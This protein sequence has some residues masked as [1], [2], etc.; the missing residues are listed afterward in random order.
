MNRRQS[1][2]L[3]AML[4]L[5]VLLAIGGL[6][7]LMHRGAPLS[8]I[9]PQVIS[10]PTGAP[11]DGWDHGAGQDCAACHDTRQQSVPEP[12]LRAIPEAA[13]KALPQEGEGEEGEGP[14]QRLSFFVEQRAYPGKSLPSGARLMAFQQTQAMAD[15][16]ARSQEFA[17]PAQR[18][19][20]IGPAPMKNSIMGQHTADVSGRV[21]AL[22]VDPRNSNVVYLGAAQGGVWKTTNGGDSWTPLT[23]DQP[24][25]AIGALALDPQHPDT[26]YAGT[27]EP[28][29]GLDN[30]YGAGILKSTN[31]GSSWQRLGASE[32][33]GLG[34]ASIVINPINSNVL[35]VASSSTGVAGP[36]QP[37]RGIFKSTNGGASWTALLTCADCYGAS[38]LVMDVRSPAKLYAAFWSAGIYK[39]TDGGATW[40]QLTGGLPP[41]NFGRIELAIGTSDPSVLYAGYHYTVQGQY[42]GAVLFKT[43]DG[44]A[45]WTWLQQTPNYCGGQCWY[46]NIIAVDPTSA[47]VVYLGGQ[48]RYEWQPVTRIKEVVIRSNDGGTTWQDMSPNDSAAHTLHPD[49]HAIAF[50]PQNHNTVWV[51]NDG[52]V[53]KSTDGGRTWINRNTNLATLQFTGIGLHPTNGN[54]VFGGMQDNNK[55]KTS[56][57][58]AWDALDAGDGGYAA[59]DPFDPRF[60]YGSRYSISFQRNDKSGSAPVADWPVKTEGISRQDRA[61][62]YAPFALDPSSQGVLYYG[63][64][65]LYRT[66]N[67]GENWMPISGD[68]TKGA[69]TNGRLSAIAVAPSAAGTI[70]VGT[71]D[72]NVQV[73]TNTGGSW[74]NATKAPLPNRW[75]SDIAVPHNDAKTAYVVYNG[76][77]SHTPQTPGHVFKTTDR[78]GSWRDISAN[79][80]DVPVLSIVLDRDGPGILYIGTDV[81]VFRSLDDGRRWQPFSDGLPNVAVVDLA[82]NPDSDVLVAATHGRSVYRL[83]IGTP[84]PTPTCTPGTPPPVTPA[85][86]LPLI[87]KR[88][89]PG[90][91]TS[92]PTHTPAGPTATPTGM[93]I[94]TPT[95]TPTVGGTVLPTRTPTATA[96]PTA[97]PTTGPSPTPT[98]T[99]GGPTPIPTEMPS[100]RV[101]FDDFSNPASGWDSGVVGSCQSDYIGG[102]YG[103]AVTTYNQ[104]CLYAAP[105]GAHANGTYE[106]V[107]YKLD[108]YDGS[109]YGL[110]F[111]LNDQ[112]SFS[113]FY[114]F[115]VDPYDQTYLLQKYD[116]GSW[117]SLT[118][119]AYSIAINAGS[120]AN[121][122]KVKREGAQIDLYVNDVYLTT[123]SDDSFPNGGHVGMANW[124]AYNAAS[125]IAYFDDFK[126]TEPTVIL[127]DDFSNPYSGW[128]VG[129]EEA[130]QA[131]YIEEEYQVATEPDYACVYRSPGGWLSSGLFEVVVRREESIYPT[132][133]GVMLGE[134]GTFSRLYVFWLNPDSQEYV[135]ALYDGGWWALTW[136]EVEDDAWT[137]SSAINPGTSTNT[138]HVMQD[139]ALISLWANG[140]YLETVND[141][142]FSGG[143]F[144]VANWAS[145]YAPSASTFDDFQVTAWEDAGAETQ[146]VQ[147]PAARGPA[148]GCLGP[149][150]M[151]DGRWK[152]EVGEREG[153]KMVN[154]KRKELQLPWFNGR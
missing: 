42:D 72:G 98:A 50:D 142:T 79:L 113:Q 102:E 85:S 23:D 131:S 6:F 32:F 123:V 45:S 143:Y 153:E 13:D 81:G 100:P 3:A 89:S 66:T 49:M 121:T 53:W 90:A 7:V 128:P 22:V 70:Y 74:S 26:I 107:A 141:V 60:Y 75:V 93:P 8:H 68:S 149:M 61:L 21:K 134:D 9:G 120:S 95:P 10:R 59:I 29:P 47:N 30:Y 57:S 16:L 96:T 140:I 154:G 2:T 58:M 44:G 19:V 118:S 15:E 17:A 51:G 1:F 112:S 87:L 92:T 76:F 138:L 133:Y 139:G 14:A 130:C 104:V 28:H 125:A 54:I 31:G 80:P 43:T 124:A 37:A 83:E 46:D 110:V 73:T 33:S 129:A 144:G 77:N 91:P 41:S 94:G 97:T 152:V 56:G 65:R 5:A 35:Y 105:T 36:S 34:I 69:D 63:T 64:H 88:F 103:V 38:D 20:N 18:W 150:R 146:A 84:P 132:T 101:F 55:A 135:L 122:L 115:W 25:L 27:G 12:D 48:A 117:T 136:D 40:T 116:S 71:S 147:P 67:R 39:S 24:S 148:S 52:G 78:G 106:I 151:E 11:A 86:Y 4:T 111:G 62:F 127:Y 108:L 145:D 119:W 109:V 137:Y 99:R 114:V 126:V 82:L